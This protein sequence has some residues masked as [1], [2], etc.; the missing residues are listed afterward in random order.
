MEISSEFH[1]NVRM[2]DRVQRPNSRNENKTRSNQQMKNSEWIHLVRTAAIATTAAVASA[3]TAIIS[4]NIQKREQEELNN[5]QA[6][7][8]IQFV[9]S[10][11]TNINAI[12]F[13]SLGSLVIELLNGITVKL[14]TI[15]NFD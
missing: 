5:K 8:I 14:F 2:G 11:Y 1:E 4:E 12:A 7:S 6:L 13:C 3:A 10:I 9:Y 15:S